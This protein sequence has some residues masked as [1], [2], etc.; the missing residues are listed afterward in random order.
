M[1]SLLLSFIW[2]FTLA[3]APPAQFVVSKVKIKSSLLGKDRYI[4]HYLH[5]AGD[6]FDELKHKRSLKILQDEL[7]DDG[8]LDATIK[9]TVTFDEP[10]KTVAV[11]LQLIPGS[12]FTFSAI[13][14]SLAGRPLDRELKQEL[15]SVLEP[16]VGSFAQKKSLNDYAKRLNAFLV[17]KG[18]VKPGIELTKKVNESRGEVELAYT[19]TLSERH[20]FRF[21]GNQ[22]LSTSDLLDD[23]FSLVD[24]GISLPSTLIAQDIQDLYKK[25]G[26][27]QAKVH[28]QEDTELVTF[29]IAE[30]E[31]HTIGKVVVLE[32]FTDGKALAVLHN[33]EAALAK[34]PAFDEEMV[35]HLLNKA[36]LELADLGYWYLVLD[37]EVARSKNAAQIDIVIS[38]TQAGREGSP[39]RM[40]V[41]KVSIPGY[42]EI[43][44]QGP[45]VEWQSLKEPRAVRPSDIDAQRRWIMSFL[46]SRGYHTARVN[47]AVDN[48]ELVWTVEELSGPVRFGPVQILGLHKMKPFIVQ[49]ELCFEEGDLWDKQKID[50]ALRRL[51]G[52]HMFESITFHPEQT[53]EHTREGLPYLTKPILIK[54]CEDDP[55]EGRTRFGLQFVSKSFTNVSWTTWKLGGSLIWKNPSGYADRFI[56]DADWTRYTLNLSASYELPWLGS[57]PIRTITKVYSDRFDQPLVSNRHQ[58]LY[59]EAHD[60]ISVTFNHVHPW[61]TTC[62]RAG[63]EVNKLSGI[64]RELA[65]VIQ[66]EPT[67]VDQRIPYFYA[68]PSVTFEHFDNKADPSRGFFSTFSLK[69][70]VPPGV[71]DGWFVKAVLEQSLFYPLYDSVIGALRWRVG[72]IFNARFSTILPT[73]RFYLGGANSLRGYETNMVPPLNDVTCDGK[74]IWVPVGGKTMANIN[75]ELRFPLYKRLSGVVFTDM[76]ILTQDR[77]ADI[78]ANRWLGASGFGL[79]VASPI[80]PIRFD[81]GW[82]W[83]KRDPRDKSYA[84]FFTLGH[85][86]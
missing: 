75:A 64:S 43:L 67:L 69:A 36:S 35:D 38:I 66:F 14:L 25:K 10:T 37:K 72:H 29:C 23:L 31:R 50:D 40:M 16:L 84:F 62:V 71:S 58:R 21:V 73:E 80:G 46:R 1:L 70:M 30:G 27:M 61:W 48:L 6:F 82:K 9:D 15:H 65:R 33:L 54:C 17:R 86:F 13:H 49:R 42:E 68:E 63:F 26:F 24:Q 59:K 44:S 8:Y 2:F 39:Q 22:F 45:F 51:Q 76:G 81:I 5:E 19:I 57:W 12:R 34:L 60:G 28:A 7:I 53:V 56:L 20:E 18:Y 85:A 52:L 41:N 79:R 47:H 77:F 11:S 83:R 55:L 3:G 78:A 74:C 4:H 32:E